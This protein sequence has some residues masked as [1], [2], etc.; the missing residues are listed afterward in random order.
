[1]NPEQ[2]KGAP[3]GDPVPQARD[4]CIMTQFER[5]VGIDV[6]KDHLEIY[7]H[8][9][10]TRYTLDNT[11]SG[12]R[13]LLARFDGETCAIGCE[14]TGGYESALL[15]ALSEAGRPG[16]CLHP[17]D[18]RAFARL[19][20]KR[21]KT[22][23]LDAKAIAQALEVAVTSRKP[24][25]RNKSQ[26]VLKELITARRTLLATI[27]NLKSLLARCQAPA[28]RQPL[29][30]MLQAH[31]DTVKQLD[32]EIRQAIASNSSMAETARRICT[33]PGAGPVLAANLI[34]NL[35]ELGA[36]SSRQAASLVGVAPHPRQSGSSKRKG[37]CQAGRANLRRVLYMATLSALKARSAPLYPFYE[38]LR[39]AG[40]PFKVAIVAA[41]RK[42]ITILNAMIKNANDWKKPETQTS[43]VA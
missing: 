14:A 10:G 12:I 28:A 41:M 18:V 16:W 32:A 7:G 3:F 15:V 13:H 2:L 19:K 1:M 26:S 27:T 25:C 38:R 43:T 21:A 34:A 31:K 36:L 4:I 8:P 30:S 35:P 9:D 22:D 11:P 33:A 6:A 37:R 17:S 39:Q 24:Q 40:K 23:A 29:T 5:F 20:G 42:F